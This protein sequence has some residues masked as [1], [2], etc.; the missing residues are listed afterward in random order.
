LAAAVTVASMDTLS[1]MEALVDV[2]IEAQWARAICLVCFT[3]VAWHHLSTV[4]DEVR[5]VWQFG[6]LGVNS[7][8]FLFIRYLTLVSFA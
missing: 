3:C 6:S 7:G 2:L 4:A 8:L 5:L 1:P